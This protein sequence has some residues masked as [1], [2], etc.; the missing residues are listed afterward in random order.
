MTA[1]AERLESLNR[2]LGGPGRLPE[3]AVR[4]TIGRSVGGLKA[5]YERSLR[6]SPTLSGG[7][8]V[9][10]EVDDEGRVISASATNNE[11]GQ[12]VSECVVGRLRSL[13]FPAPAGGLTRLACPF[14]FIPRE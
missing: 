8:T 10:I 13:R 11:V 4:Q 9:E 7:L 1:Q 5:C 6:S 14:I 3:D 2:T 12:E